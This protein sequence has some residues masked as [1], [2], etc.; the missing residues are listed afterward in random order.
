MANLK[1]NVSNEPYSTPQPTI[2]KIKRANHKTPYYNSELAERNGSRQLP[3]EPQTISVKKTWRAVFQFRMFMSLIY[4]VW[5]QWS[6]YKS[7]KYSVLQVF[8]KGAQI[9]CPQRKE[10]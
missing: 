2:P 8:S 5:N 4:F 3:Y 7:I 10:L 9:K 1:K 6:V